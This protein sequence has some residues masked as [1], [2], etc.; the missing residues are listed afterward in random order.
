MRGSADQVF[1]L[2]QLGKKAREKKQTMLVGSMDSENETGGYQRRVMSGSEDVQYYT[3]DKLFNAIK[4]SSE[5][6]L[7]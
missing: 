3:G 5:I 7:T 6:Q 1:V 4:S 2:K